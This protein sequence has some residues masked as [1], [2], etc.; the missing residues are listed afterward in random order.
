[1]CYIRRFSQFVGLFIIMVFLEMT[2]T[3]LWRPSSLIHQIMS[4]SFYVSKELG[5]LFGTGVG[6]I[7]HLIVTEQTYIREQATEAVLRSMAIIIELIVFPIEM[8][9]CF[10]KSFE[11]QVSLWIES[12]I[13]DVQSSLSID[14]WINVA[15]FMCGAMMTLCWWA[16]E[17][18]ISIIW[19]IFCLND[20]V[21]PLSLPL[22]SFLNMLSNKAS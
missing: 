15:F 5:A 21:V 2:L 16:A 13:E 11:Q 1:M 3:T 9:I 6:Q 12:S 20:L 17:G 4:M 8:Y 19:S 10:H 18:I 14:T 7:I 22:T